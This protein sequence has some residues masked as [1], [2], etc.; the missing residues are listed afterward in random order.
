MAPAPTPEKAYAKIRH[1]CAYQERS[2]QEVKDR[3]Y[4]MGLHQKDVDTLLYQLI[5][6]NFLNEARFAT[7]YAGGH[8]RIKKWGR[9]KIMYELRQKKVSAYN[10]KAAL[11]EIPETDYLATLQQ[12]ATAK[13]SQLKGTPSLSRQAKTSAYLMRKGYEGGLVLGVVRGL[14]AG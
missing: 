9:V 6:E 11:K 5:E 1:Y 12:L 14:G 8:F 2:H 10:I 13:W 3:L 4:G 7:Q